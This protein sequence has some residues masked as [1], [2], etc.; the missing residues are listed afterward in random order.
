MQTLEDVLNDVMAR[1]PMLPPGVS[2]EVIDRLPSVIEAITAGILEDAAIMLA[3][4]DL[5][6]ESVV[7]TITIGTHSAHV[8]ISTNAEGIA[9]SNGYDMRILGDHADLNVNTR[10]PRTQV[11]HASR[12]GRHLATERAAA[13]IDEARALMKTHPI[14]KDM[15]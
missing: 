13:M 9:V 5:G 12:M 2:R 4:E 10:F 3:F 11:D 14:F 7:L 8:D 6:S 15:P 1:M